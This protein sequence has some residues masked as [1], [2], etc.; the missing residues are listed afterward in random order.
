MDSKQRCSFF[1][2]QIFKIYRHAS[3][4]KSLVIIY[5]CYERQLCFTASMKFLYNNKTGFANQQFHFPL[6]WPRL[7]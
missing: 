4:T 6:P 1:I 3:K 7:N 2:D 5:R